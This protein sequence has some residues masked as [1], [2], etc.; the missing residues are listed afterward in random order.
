[1]SQQLCRV[2]YALAARED[3]I[4]LSMFHQDNLELANH[5]LFVIS[6]GIDLLKKH[7]LVGRQLANGLRALVISHGNTGYLARYQYDALA[8]LVLVLAIK[9]QREVDDH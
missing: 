4:R 7:P 8:N 1:M 9:H 3:L 2:E 5:I 6:D